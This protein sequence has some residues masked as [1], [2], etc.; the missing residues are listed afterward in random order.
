[1]EETNN[2]PIIKATSKNH[3]PVND[4]GKKVMEDYIVPKSKDVIHDALAGLT[5]MIG[6]AIQGA[7]N[8]AIYGEDRPQQSSSGHTGYSTFYTK[9]QNISVSSTV[10][11]SIGKRSS[12]EVKYIWVQSEEDARLITNTMRDN[13]SQY[14][15]CKVADLYEMVTPK[16]QTT[17]QDYK[18]GWVDPNGI[19]YHKEY[20]GEHRGEYILDLAKPIDVTNV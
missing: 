9:P 12:T 1:M 6:D 18:F 7:I 2:K 11:N 14:G 15:K 16:I 4:I 3:S 19:G 20:T 17:F 10:S 5:S 8:Q 13:I